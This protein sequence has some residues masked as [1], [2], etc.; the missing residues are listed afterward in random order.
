M[1]REIVLARNDARNREIRRMTEPAEWL[2]PPRHINGGLFV[3]T[4]IM[5][6]FGLVMLFSASMSDG[7]ANKGGDSMYYVIKQAGITAMGLAAAMIVA[8]AVPVR[9]FDRYWLTVLVYIGTTGLLVYVKLFGQVIN[10]AR[11]WVNLGISFQPSELAKLAMVFCLAGYFSALR[12][13]RAAGKPVKHRTLLGGF[14]ADGWSDVLI[15]SGLMLLWIGLIVLQPHVSCAII[16]CFLLLVCLLAAGIPFRSWLSAITQLLVFVLI[17]ALLASALLPLLATTELRQ[18]LEDNFRHAI[19]RIE[20]FTKPDEASADDTYQINQSIIAIG[21]GGLSGVGLGSGRQKYNYLPEAH[22]D[23]VFAI[24]GEEL[25]FIGTLAVLLLFILFMLIGVSITSKASNSF[26]AILAGGFTML[27]TVQ[28]LLNIG[29]ATRTIPSTGISLPFFSYGGTSN[30]FFLM[31]IGFI[32]AV[33]RTGQRGQHAP[34]QARLEADS[35]GG[36]ALMRTEN[37]PR[38]RS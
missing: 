3:V 16:M 38:P 35:P 7:Y 29:V 17:L 36:D 30:L 5:I 28:A 33:S 12:R 32:L 26:A 11:R 34:L 22:N 15:P 1:K 4:L 18:N 37:N 19:K 6:C 2:Q 13:R 14:L 31:A 20:T 9:L 25:G 8:L 24:I 23:F 21:S 27:I 10:G